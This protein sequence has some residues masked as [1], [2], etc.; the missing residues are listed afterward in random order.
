MPLRP[1]PAEI[2]RSLAVL[3]EAGDVCECRIPKSAQG[4][5]SGYFSDREAL[6][7]ALLA[8]NGAANVYLTLNPCRPELLARCANRLAPH[9]KVATSDKD[10]L[11]RRWL[12]LDFD[13]V[14]PS[15]I[16][17]SDREHAA[18][19]LRARAVQYILTR[20]HWPR[21]ILADSGNGAHLLYLIDLANDEA[22]TKLVEGVLK[23]LARRFDSEQVKLDQTVYNAA[24]IT[25]AY[26]TPAKKGD[27]I[28]ERPHRLSRLLEVPSQLYAVPR[29][30]LEAVAATLEPPK[31]QAATTA[32]RAGSFDLEAFI[33]RYLKA[34]EPVAHEGGRKWVLEEC[35]FNS[36]HKAPDA[37]I[38]QRADN[39]IGF[40][41]FHNSCAGKGWQ[42][43][44]G[45]FEGPRASRKVT[46][47]NVLAKEPEPEPGEGDVIPSG[48]EILAEV[49][50]MIRRYVVMPDG[51]QL[52]AALWTVATHAA[53]QFDC[54]PYLAPMSAAKRSGKTR[55]LE[56]LETMVDRPWRGVSPSP[57]VLYRELATG[58]TL[59]LDEV[60]ALNG[61]N[62]TE[63]TL[64]LLAALNAGHRK[65][66][67]ISRCEGPQHEIRKFDVYGPKAFAGIG[68]LPDTLMDRSIII[69]MKRRTKNQPVKRFR[70]V[71][72]TA[73]GKS[74]RRN[75]AQW[76]RQNRAAI[77]EAYQDVLDTE[78]AFLGDRDADLWTPLF[79]VCAVI[80][81]ARLAELKRNAIT[82]STSKAGAD[83]EDSYALTLLRDIKMIWPE[84]Q[85]KCETAVLIEKLK[86]LEESP[87]SEHQLTPRKLARMLRPFEVEPRQVRVG[88]R[89]VKGYLY[90]H[91]KTVFDP[92]LDEISETCVTNQ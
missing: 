30:L 90:M 79:A 69:P 18:V 63:A 74:I 36:D 19:L 33:A 58:P 57:A 23:A 16:S 52:P 53:Q 71:R 48:E 13:A 82:L 73:E 47:S 34:R 91:L 37:A 64:I 43:V 9:A 81:P 86:A 38:F 21:G 59:L 72:A 22:A 61:K 32:P 83:V 77:D 87:W 66:N 92:Y 12:L 25:K 31:T 8:Q 76:A 80:S 70:L 14:R 50:N 10:I 65:G 5:I 39:T 6:K 89:T 54:Y 75:A 85:D 4:T 29:E 78:M 67:P 27:N 55:L 11:R 49:E 3:F 35:P 62:K 2:D 60:E 1:D 41:C 20:E 44:R 88:D 68:R 42:D 26:G 51:S 7:R 46:N 84:G 40:K 24:R 28:E 56:V 45:R 15:E 17:S